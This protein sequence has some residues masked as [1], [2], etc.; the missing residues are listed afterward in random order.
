MLL[1]GVDIPGLGGWLTAAHT[2]EDVDRTVQAVGKS[3]EMLK[4]DG[5]VQ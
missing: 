2:P 4:A 1:N 3:I 5:I